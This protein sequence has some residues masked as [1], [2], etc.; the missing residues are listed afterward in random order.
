[1]LKFFNRVGFLTSTEGQGT[2]SIGAALS[3]SMLTPAEAGAEDGDE[4]AFVIEDGSDFEIVRGVIGGSVTTLTR[5]SVANSKIGGVA[6]TDKIEL[7]GSARVRFISDALLANTLWRAVGGVVQ[8]ADTA[9]PELDA[10]LG[11]VFRLEATAGRVI[12]VPTYP[13]SGQKIVIQHYASGGAR[14]LGLNTGAGG[15]RFGVDVTGLTETASGK[16]D[17]I[18]AIFNAEDNFWDVVAYAKGY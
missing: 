6:G 16:T 13:R 1:M 9:T 17:Y 12:A 15:F 3:P 8:L 14:M 7:S 18:G 10:S 4:T 11:N 2:I 5:V